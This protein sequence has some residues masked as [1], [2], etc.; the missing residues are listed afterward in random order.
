MGGH[1]VKL[2]EWPQPLPPASPPPG[3]RHGAAAGHTAAERD[4]PG[5][6]PTPVEWAQIVARAEQADDD[7]S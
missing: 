4:D 6:A 7:A 3:A 2:E 5:H 1:P